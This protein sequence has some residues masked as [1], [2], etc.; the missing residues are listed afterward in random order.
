[1]IVFIVYTALV[2]LALTVISFIEMAQGVNL[3]TG[4][5]AVLFG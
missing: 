2:G 5:P 1:M 3:F 4:Q